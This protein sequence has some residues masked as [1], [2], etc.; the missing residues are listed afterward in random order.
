MT[1]EPHVGNSN[2]L[3]LVRLRY[4]KQS[5]STV[6]RAKTCTWTA[7]MTVPYKSTADSSQLS[8]YHRGGATVADS[9]SFSPEHCVSGER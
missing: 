8:C 1:Q 9:T 5:P 6:L 4:G 3:N 7:V 2:R